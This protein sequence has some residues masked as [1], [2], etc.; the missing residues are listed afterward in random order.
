[1][2]FYFE[3]A[4]RQTVKDV[5]DACKMSANNCAIIGNHVSL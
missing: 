3:N 2:A 1:M 4:N 5:M